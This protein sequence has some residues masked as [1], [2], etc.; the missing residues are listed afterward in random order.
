MVDPATL[1]EVWAAMAVNKGLRQTD[2]AVWTLLN[3]FNGDGR[4]CYGQ[5]REELCRYLK[6]DER[7]F[8]EATA[9]LTR[10][11]YLESKVKGRARGNHYVT[12][13]GSVVLPLKKKGSTT[14][15]A[16]P[17]KVE[18]QILK[19]STTVP[20]LYRKEQKK[21]E[22]PLLTDPQD[23]NVCEELRPT[24]ADQDPEA[25]LRSWLVRYPSAFLR[26]K[27]R[28]IAARGGDKKG[29]AYFEKVFAQDFEG[30]TPPRAEKLLNE[31]TAGW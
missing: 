2:V 6:I 10:A 14:V 22:E 17:Q 5:T 4:G 15:P 21:R 20:L 11:G 18:L 12:K 8:T 13:G 27:I 23:R 25:V 24:F 3:S 30:W 31:R 28:E 26:T 29:R 19:G 9:R 16:L 1:R 7:A